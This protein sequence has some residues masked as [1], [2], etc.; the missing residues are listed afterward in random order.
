[1]VAPLGTGIA[2]ADEQ[3][4]WLQGRKCAV[5][6]RM[7]VCH[8][9]GVRWQASA[10]VVPSWSGDKNTIGHKAH[11]GRV[12]PPLRVSLKSLLRAER[13]DDDHWAVRRRG[14]QLVYPRHFI[15][16]RA[17]EFAADGAHSACI[18][19]QRVE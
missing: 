17:I 16:C 10:H 3:F 8:K 12:P 18:Q 6:E 7:L 11:K 15:A 14:C 5:I 13:T 19:C 9:P 4:V 1:M 2:Q